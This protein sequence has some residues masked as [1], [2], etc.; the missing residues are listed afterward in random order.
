MSRGPTIR[1]SKPV[2][3]GLPLHVRAHAA[4]GGRLPGGGPDLHTQPSDPRPE[5]R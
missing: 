3:P 4:H 1:R 2:Q 5:C